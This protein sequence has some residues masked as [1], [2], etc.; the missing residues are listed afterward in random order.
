[1]P[2]NQFF[3][4]VTWSQN[5]VNGKTFTPGSEVS[6]ELI[7]RSRIY[8]NDTNTANAPGY[9]IINVR[10][11]QKYKFHEVN[12]TSYAAIDNLLNK[13][14]IGSVIVNASSDR[15]FE[16]A[17]PRNYTLGLQASLPF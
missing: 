2:A 3:G 16:P 17:L 1:V 6:T 11:Q 14:A 10:A 4:S 15:F 5:P 13:K 7:S 9:S 8:A 12:I